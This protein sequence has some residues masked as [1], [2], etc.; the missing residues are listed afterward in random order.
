MV[1]SDGGSWFTWFYSFL[2][3]VFSLPVGISEHCICKR[4][5]G[6]S[7]KGSRGNKL[8]GRC[9]RVC[10]EHKAGGGEG[11]EN[12]RVNKKL[13]GKSLE[14]TDDTADC[15]FLPSVSWCWLCET[16]RG[17]GAV[18][19]PRYVGWAAAQERHVLYQRA[20]NSVGAGYEMD[21]SRGWDQ[22]I[23]G[24]LCHPSSAPWLF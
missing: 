4:L 12:W 17:S 20:G 7:K 11:P 16:G 9:R 1:F 14:E 22:W 13:V 2:I 5:R 18:L 21:S 8:L 23:F 15:I 24:L 6:G 19:P 3:S 10:M